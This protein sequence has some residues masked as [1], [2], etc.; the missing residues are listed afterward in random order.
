MPHGTA[1]MKMKKGGIRRDGMSG[2]CILHLHG[3]LPSEQ[4]S[5]IGLLDSVASS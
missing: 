1:I 3:T 4:R 5:A 2:R